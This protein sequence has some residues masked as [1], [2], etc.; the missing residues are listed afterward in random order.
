MLTTSSEDI[1][2]FFYLFQVPWS[3]RR[4]LDFGRAVPREF[5]RDDFGEERGFLVSKIFPMGFANSVGIAQHVH[6]NVV[7]RCMGSLRPPLGG[8]SGLRRDRPFSSS[9][10]LFRIYLDNY[11]LLNKTD[12][13]TT[14][15]L[16]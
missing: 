2:C 11:D 7:R 6:R 4:F 5:L 14:A 13:K 10:S 3:W 16:A 9:S 8:E 15:L 1:K 12:P